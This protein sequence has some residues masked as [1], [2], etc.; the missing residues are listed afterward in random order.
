MDRLFEQMKGKKVHIVGITGAEGSSILRLLVK[1]G[2]IDITGHDF[3]AEKSVEKSFKLWHKGI[4]ADEKKTIFAQFIQ[5]T[6]SIPAFYNN[7]YL[8]DIDKAD[9]IFVPQS[10][11]LYPEQNRALYEAKK[12]GIPFYSLTRLYLDYSN[13]QIIAVTGTVGKGSVAHLIAQIL[14]LAGKSVYFAGNDTWRLQVADFL[15]QMYP[16]DF[17]VVEISHRQ[18]LDGFAKAPYMAVF[19]NLYPN[20]LD[21]VSFE[22]YQACKWS[23]FAKQTPADFS[24]INYDDEILRIGSAKLDSKVVYYSHKNRNM[25]TKNV[26]KQYDAIM[27]TNSSQFKNNILASITAVDTLDINITQFI[28][29]LD[30]IPQLAARCELIGQTNGVLLYDD[31]KSTTPWATL[32]ALTKLANVLLIC[33]GE[34]KGLDYSQFA[35]V[36]AK[37]TKKVI[38]LKSQLSDVLAYYLPEGKYIIVD[39]LKGA[40]SHAL[41]QASMG[42][43]ILISPAAAFFYSQFIKG[44]KSIKKVIISLLPEGRSVKD[45][46]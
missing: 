6:N 4:S 42:D 9:I 14:K 5:D 39:S 13:A 2:N 10:W 19:T 38:I 46:H 37:S 1:Q 12:K 41:E 44:K 36:L 7:N 3:L 25:N 40:I 22:Q 23:L 15:P 24:V 35:K 17:L 21:E 18:L 34:T 28:S 32:A 8:Q 11:R 27:N 20:H 31:I 30:N 33:G 29:S 26:Q 16:K 43:I 45:L